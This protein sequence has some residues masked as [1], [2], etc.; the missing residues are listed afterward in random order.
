MGVV[1]ASI[2]HTLAAHG[3]LGRVFLTLRPV[4]M[5]LEGLVKAQTLVLELEQAGSSISNT[6][7]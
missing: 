1:Q 6:R 4:Y 2:Q 5:S 7:Y 3:M